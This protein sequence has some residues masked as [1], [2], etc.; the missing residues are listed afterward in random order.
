MEIK[1]DFL[2]F[3]FAGVRSEDLGFVRVSGGD[4]YEEQLQPEVKDV[5]AE[6]PGMDGEYYFG[7]TYSPKQIDI[8]IAFDSMTERQFRQIRKIFG[9]RQQGELIFDERPYKKY[10]A[11]IE[12]PIELSYVCFDEPVKQKYSEVNQILNP[13][14]DLPDGIRVIERETHTE[15]I[16][17]KEVTVTSIT[18][19]KI[20]PWVVDYTQ[21][22][23]VYKG[24]G[25][26]SFTCYFPFAKSTFKVLPELGNEYYEGRQ[27][28]A[29]SSGILPREEYEL[30]DKYEDGVIKIYNAGDLPTGFRL[31]CPFTTAEPS[32][33]ETE[34]SVDAQTPMTGTQPTYNITLTYK[35]MADNSIVPAVLQI[36]D[37]EPQDEDIGIII[38]TDTG[39]IQGVDTFGHE[40]GNASYT[41]SGNLYN[42]YVTAGYFFKLEPNNSTG[43]GATIQI[44]GGN[45]GMEIF[46][47]Y[48]Y[49]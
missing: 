28:W 38:N 22:Q 8:E 16:D 49:F 4:R 14:T 3:T 30:I 29:V 17:D 37:L 40:Y 19:E 44:T 36:E 42:E 32:D 23:R 26:I 15:T 21:T 27:D 34:E 35:S 13:A 20:D 41:T 43:D 11:K 48:L 39:L 24:E 45:D 46:Y 12:S 6:V 33:A 7:S 25:K 18:R 31:Y 2:G 1:G 5:T 9:R 47:D 10:L